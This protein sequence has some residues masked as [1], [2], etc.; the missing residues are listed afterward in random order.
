L[1]K[2]NQHT[3]QHLRSKVSLLNKQGQEM[4]KSLA[5]SENMA[6]SSTMPTKMWESWYKSLLQN[7]PS[8]FT[9]STPDEDDDDVSE[10]SDIIMSDSDDEDNS[11]EKEKEKEESEGKD[12]ESGTVRTSKE[13][14]NKSTSETQVVTA[15]TSSRR[16]NKRK[17]KV[18]KQSL[19][20]Y[21]VFL[22]SEALERSIECALLRFPGPVD[23]QVLACIFGSC[24]FPTIDSSLVLRILRAF[25]QVNLG[26]QECEVLG[27]FFSAYKHGYKTL[28]KKVA[29]AEDEADKIRR[30]IDSQAEARAAAVGEGM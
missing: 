7:A 26:R 27:R 19:T 21:D 18:Y 11:E 17:S 20:F 1:Y 13:D 3:V 14:N 9:T 16:S 30:K 8:Y 6:Y 2:V 10:T 12:G 25:S 24:L 4:V 29:H 22:Q 5:Q 28:Q 23:C 15:S